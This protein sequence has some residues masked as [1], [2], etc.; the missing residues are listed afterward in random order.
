MAFNLNSNQGPAPAPGAGGFSFGSTVAPTSATPAT[1]SATLGLAPP[2]ASF[3]SFGNTATSAPAA[4]TTTPGLSFGTAPAAAAAPTPGAP[5]AA[6]PSTTNAPTPG[7]PVAGPA[8]TGGF[9]FG[10]TPAA[11]AASTTTTP[12]AAAAAPGPSTGFAFGGTPAPS[13]TTPAPGAGAASTSGFSFGNTP[14]PASVP[15]NTTAGTPAAAAPLPPGEQPALEAPEFDSVFKNLELWSQIQK[16]VNQDSLMAGQEL[17]HCVKS[18]LPDFKPQLLEFTP[19]NQQL[20][21]QLAAKRTV[22]VNK[23]GTTF[24]SPRVLERIVDLSNELHISEAQATT[25]YAQISNDLEAIQSIPMGDLVDQGMGTSKKYA[26]TTKVAREFYFYERHLRLQ[27]LL[28]MMQSRLKDDTPNSP[29]IQATDLL[30]ENGIVLDL[31]QFIKDYTTRIQQLQTATNPPGPTTYG[32]QA[33]PPPQSST[34]NF[35]KVHLLFAN[36]ERYVACECLFFIAYHIQL[37]SSEMASLLD[38]IKELS[39]LT[40]VLS[41]F[42]NVPSPYDPA[43][44]ASTIP[45]SFPTT[46]APVPFNFAVKDKD[47]LVWQRELVAETFVTGVPQVLQ[48]I[49]LLVVAAIAAMETRQVLYDRKIHGPNAFGTVRMPNSRCC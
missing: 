19:P 8:A 16:L 34:P 12:A 18:H 28:F 3:P 17:C 47:P 21:Q 20:R 30:M 4:S 9:N 39:R 14:A 36:Q 33:Q 13:A 31:I 27:T 6:P 26:T 44:T 45:T 15:G 42:T 41:P 37:T 25:L 5:G 43:S 49:S 48:S 46:S 40:P 35:D 23:G 10:G 1:T 22:S 32:Y 11:P 24:L 7:A 29:I 38:L 2:A